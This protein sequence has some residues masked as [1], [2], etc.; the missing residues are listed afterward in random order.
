MSQRSQVSRIALCMAK[1]KVSQLVS[2]L[3][4][5]SPIEL[6]W[7]AKTPVCPQL[8]HGCVCKDVKSEKRIQDNFLVS[9]LLHKSK[10]G[11]AKHKT[12]IFRYNDNTDSRRYRIIEPWGDKMSFFDFCFF[13]GGE[14]SFVSIFRACG[15]KRLRLLSTLNARF[16]KM[17]TSGE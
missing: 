14:T 10:R 17:E 1:V 3:V 16:W 7:T 8:C 13:K 9:Y 12:S 11:Q 6:L 4:T 5:R 15:R 2:Q